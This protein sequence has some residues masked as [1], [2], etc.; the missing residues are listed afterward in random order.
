[1]GLTHTCGGVDLRRH[2]YT[3]VVSTQQEWYEGRS[4]EEWHTSTQLLGCV[5]LATGV[6][7]L[8]GVAGLLRVVEGCWELLGD[9]GDVGVKLGHVES[10]GLIE[11]KYILAASM[12]R[13]CNARVDLSYYSI[14]IR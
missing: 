3:T 14:L 5:E 10:G 2:N 1:M 12:A 7:W 6:V 8:L 4:A 11:Y 9:V 13:M